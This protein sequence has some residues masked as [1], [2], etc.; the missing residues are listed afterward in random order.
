MHG[1]DSR[2]TTKV[3]AICGSLKKNSTTRKALRIALS[4]AET[5]GASVSL[6]DLAYYNLAFCNGDKS[7][8]A[9]GADFARLRGEIRS[10]HGLIVAT[11]EYHGS[12]SGLLKN[13][14]DLHEIEDL[15]GKVVAIVA[16]AGGKQGGNGALTGLRSVFKALKA[17][18]L[19]QD[20]SVSESHKAF[21]EDGS[22][23]DPSLQSRLQDLGRQTARFAALHSETTLAP[24]VLEKAAP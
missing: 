14:L 9:K 1:N 24:N 18:V 10:S 15:Q 16:T 4:G 12:F 21:A 19:P 8:D 3:L 17:W 5:A 11:P 20:V 22:A 2:E 13:A 6:V 23:V 7:H